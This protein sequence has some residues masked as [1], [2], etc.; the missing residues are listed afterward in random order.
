MPPPQVDE[1]SFEEV[2]WEWYQVHSNY[3][4]AKYYHLRGVDTSNYSGDL[5]K[6][7]AGRD[8]YPEKS[9]VLHRVIQYYLDSRQKIANAHPDQE[10]EYFQFGECGTPSS[11]LKRD[12]KIKK[13]DESIDSIDP[14]S[15][16]RF[17]K[18]S[19]SEKHDPIGE[20]H[21]IQFAYKSKKDEMVSYGDDN[22]FNGRINLL[23]DEN[24]DIS[25]K[26]ID[27]RSDFFPH[28][29]KWQG[30][31]LEDRIILDSSVPVPDSD[32]SD[33]TD[34]QLRSIAEKYGRDAFNI[35]EAL[36]I[37]SDIDWYRNY[38]VTIS[39]DGEMQRTCQG[40]SW[41]NFFFS[42]GTDDRTTTDPEHESR[43]EARKRDE[44]ITQILEKIEKGE[45]P[46]PQPPKDPEPQP[47]PEP[48]P[49]P[50]PEPEPEPGP[51]PQPEDPTPKPELEPEDPKPEPNP[52]PQPEE[53]NPQPKPEYPEAKPKPKPQPEDPSTKP[54]P[55]P[56]P[57]NPQSNPKQEVTK[58][59]KTK[60]PQVNETDTPVSETKRDTK[61]VSTQSTRNPVA[62]SIPI[63]NIQEKQSKKIIQEE[64]TTVGPKVN[65]G[66]S[67]ASSFFD[68]LLGIFS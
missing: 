31:R 26:Y 10:F 53:P 17:I 11:T 35:I 2:S 12:E 29:K 51:K 47:E 50:K 56:E 45:L 20:V 44:I 27:I 8:V 57:G 15:I 66:G 3:E 58:T 68:K 54:E 36:K 62:S 65:T 32:N 5:D 64:N 1:S 63:Q 48:E 41:R 23:P 4:T 61:T 30:T 25:L 13:L 22:S 9:S 24:G 18:K 14:R 34:P 6:D 37:N 21:N 43:K 33:L 28:D 60:N 39:D 46:K 67:S 19:K 16:I 42:F 59:P 55:D 7:F 40:K 52:E 49:K 38:D